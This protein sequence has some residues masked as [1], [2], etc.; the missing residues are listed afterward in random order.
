MDQ[1]QEFNRI[2]KNTHIIA[3][4]TSVN[5]VPNVRLM[6]FYYD[7]EKKGVVYFTAFKGSPKALEFS[8]NNTVSFTTVP[9]G[10]HEHARVANGIVKESELKLSELL[11]RYI[12]KYPGIEK[13]FQMSDMMGVYEINFEEADVIMGMNQHNKVVL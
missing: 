12:P 11:D 13:V 5:N 9:V 3:L 4:A 1:L 8:Q 7:S 2:M 10:T 6:N